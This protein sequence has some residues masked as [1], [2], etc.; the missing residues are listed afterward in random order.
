MLR[1]RHF[2]TGRTDGQR[3]DVIEVRHQCTRVTIS[4]THAVRNTDNEM[5]R[6][7]IE[8]SRAEAGTAAQFRASAV[9]ESQRATETNDRG[10]DERQ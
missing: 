4:A 3:R 9:G 2:H 8:L 6:A 5:T 1:R 10:C 7:T